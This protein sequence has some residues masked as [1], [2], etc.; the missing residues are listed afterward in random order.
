MQSTLRVIR[1]FLITSV[2]IACLLSITAGFLLYGSLPRYD[3]E[4]IL[5]EL[6]APVLIDRD[7]L[8]SVT[9]QSQNRPDLA[10]AMG[11]V[12]AQERFF[13]MDL[14]RRQAAGELAELLGASL[15]SHDR[16]TRQFRMRARALAAFKQLPDEHKQL[17]D[18]Y[19]IGVNQGM[20]ALTVRPFPYLL[21]QTHPAA[22][23]AE[24]SLL[25]IFA[26]FFT[27]NDENIYRELKLSSM[28]A[29]LPDSVYQFLTSQAG[30]WDAPL[31]DEP[32]ALPELPPVTDINLQTLHE[33][34]FY[35]DP[36]V[37]DHT[38]GSNSFA[39]SGALTDGS[40]L[41]ANDMH[42]TL[43][44][45][46]VWF[47]TRLIYS[48]ETLSNRHDITGIS[49]PGVPSI[50][51]GSNRHI[52]W[53]FTNSYGDF[54]D[55]VRITIDEKDRTRY[56]SPTGWKP[57]DTMQETIRVRN[58]ADEILTISETEW[59]PII[60]QDHDETPLA[61]AWTALKPGA[62]NLKL[63][64]LE[65]TQ[66]AEQAAAVVQLAGMPAQNFIAGDRHGHISWTLAGRIPMRSGNYDPQ[67]PADWTT[68]DTG[69]NGWLS[70]ERYPLIN[71]PASQRLWSANARALSGE[72][73][74]LLGNGG[75]DLG[76][77][78]T[79]IRDSL[80]A[81]NQFTPADMHAI[82]LDHRA[83][84][85]AHW[86]QLLKTTLGSANSNSSWVAALK[87]ALNDWNDQASTNS[88]AYRVVRTYRY[89]VMKTVLNGFAAQVRL[90]HATFELP[91]LSQAEW[92][93]RQLLEHQ[94]QH[95]LPAK[96]QNWE[97]LLHQ[98]A[99]AVASQLQQNGGITERSWGEYNAARIRHPLSQKLPAWIAHWL[100]MPND[101]L[102]GDHNMPRVQ[103]PDF[104]ASQRSVVAPGQEELG[105]MDMPGGQSGH[106]LSPYYGSGHANWVNG[107]PTPFLPD[108]AE[109]R[110][111]LIPRN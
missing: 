111:R 101:P 7:A 31:I 60:A 57:I 84:L 59:G 72:Q 19:R 25:V 81:R 91:R 34:L 48:S 35:D 71:N 16:K 28:R 66:T 69:W 45:P 74:A 56:L 65:Q 1:Y 108:A 51:V 110:M 6:S 11:Y 70:A 32:L 49:L 42:L 12:H 14:M 75:Y 106:P 10:M 64:E 93:V 41:V 55:W 36:P 2:V 109:R 38:P 3:G 5:A 37:S 47:R 107:K 85:S 33:R 46:N 89:E 105:Y 98:C 90:Q 44:V 94:P 26:M 39:V 95:L 61:L 97:E 43:R 73:L 80:F 21:T 13:E 76:A 22:W 18:A 15:L 62:I 52:A 30:D 79:Q 86:Y 29:T 54:A 100:D 40:A 103:S 102:P 50:V 99:Q 68:P 27:L 88:V 67:I 63:I 83:L 82:Q 8:G 96:Y 53:S 20:Q 78:A 4:T 77:R 92:I 24:D 104:G 87:A 17:L 58:A 23:R 9:L